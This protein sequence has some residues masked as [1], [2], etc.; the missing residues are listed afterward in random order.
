MPLP[1]SN[2]LNPALLVT[3]ESGVDKGAKKREPNAAPAPSATRPGLASTSFTPRAFWLLWR[4]HEASLMNYALKMM[5]RHEQDAEDA[6]SITRLKAARSLERMPVVEPAQFAWLKQILA[7]VCIDL[8]RDRARS[9]RVMEL[10]TQGELDVHPRG[11][12]D[13]E[14]VLERRRAIERVVLAAAALPVSLRRPLV[15][16][17]VLEWS[18]DR[19]GTHLGIS[20]A[21][22]RKRVQLARQQLLESMGP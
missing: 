22:A 9:G 15:L 2:S 13:P 14:G 8:H 3:L 6:M 1:L 12:P 19:I 17:I 7:N 5:A 10:A 21:N 16:R 20:P 18:Y 11:T 4:K